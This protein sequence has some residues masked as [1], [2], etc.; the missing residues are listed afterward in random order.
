MTQL[1]PAVTRL[2]GLSGLTALILSAQSKRV[3]QNDDVVRLLQGNYSAGDV[4]TRKKAEL[5]ARHQV[6]SSEGRTMV[7]KKR[8]VDGLMD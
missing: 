2:A 5:M 3:F 1:V 8:M 7:V 6:Y 4:K